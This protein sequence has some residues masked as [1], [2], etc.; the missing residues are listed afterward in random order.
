MNR[1]IVEPC[2]SLWDFCIF[3]CVSASACAVQFPSEELHSPSSAK[4]Y[5]IDLLSRLQPAAYIMRLHAAEILS[6]GKVKFSFPP[7]LFVSYF[8]FASPLFLLRHAA[9]TDSWYRWL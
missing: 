6:S 8:Y 3:T 2:I 4:R 9:L 1:C 5:I 7:L